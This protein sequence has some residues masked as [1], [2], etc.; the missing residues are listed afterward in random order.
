MK[1]LHFDIEIIIE[2]VQYFLC[3]SFTISTHKMIRN[4]NIHTLCKLLKEYEKNDNNVY[5]NIRGAK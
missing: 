4:L 5:I 2:Y 3:K 1:E